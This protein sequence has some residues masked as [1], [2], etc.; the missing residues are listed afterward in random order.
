MAKSK[1]IAK[2]VFLPTITLYSFVFIPYSI[3]P[4]VK[5][6]LVL[7]DDKVSIIRQLIWL[8]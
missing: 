2:R 1:K 6:R 4:V 3:Y 7:A 5:F 8:E